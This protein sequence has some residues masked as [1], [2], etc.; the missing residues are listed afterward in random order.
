MSKKILL[1]STGEYGDIYGAALS[2]AMREMAPGIT[3][4]FMGSPGRPGIESSTAG[5]LNSGAVDARF[6]C[7]I[8][9]DQ[10]CLNIPFLKK[11]KRDDTTV[12]YYG[13]TADGPPKGTALKKVSAL[14]DMALAQFPSETTP[15]REAGIKV[16][17]VGH[18]LVDIM[19]SSLS[20]KEAKAVIGYDRTELPVSII[21]GDGG[22]PLLRKMFEG[23]AEAAAVSTRK[24]RLVVPDAERYG[25][26]ILNDLVKIS[27][28]RI[29]VLKGQRQAALRASEVA[30]VAAGPATLE[31]ALAGT[32]MITIKKTALLSNFMNKLMKKN[33][34]A[35]LPN[36]ILNRPLCP[37]LSRMEAKPIKITQ[38]LAGLIESSTKDEIDRGLAEIKERLGP[39]GTVRRAAEAVLNALETK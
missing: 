35:S 15:Y 6:D 13:G 10:P 2:A 38:E 11:V 29:K 33:R 19:E 4:K 26:G 39:Q 7:I 28:K 31:A 32:H 8:L 5:A 14:T 34:F 12:I 36:I 30:V 21:P 37:E 16:D 24:V 27:P 22:E 9:T 20:L 17:F 18:P 23:A 1:V 3:V 25:E